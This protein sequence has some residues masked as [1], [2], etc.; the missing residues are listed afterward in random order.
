MGDF[1]SYLVVQAAGD[2]YPSI[3]QGIL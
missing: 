3:Y 1:C 2:Y